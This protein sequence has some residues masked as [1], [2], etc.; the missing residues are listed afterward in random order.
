[1][2]ETAPR[3][4]VAGNWKM[5]HKGGLGEALLVKRA[6]A[7][8]PSRC[9]VALCPPATL[10]SAMHLD[11][12]DSPILIGGQDCHPEAS[13]AFTGDIS[14][15]ALK[16]AGAELVILGAPRAIEGDRVRRGNRGR[17]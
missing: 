8:R 10:I 14:A 6:L 16:D 12:V 2:A 7:E 17:T 9:D 1:M 5:N 13:G 4:L 11:L 3:R 15:E